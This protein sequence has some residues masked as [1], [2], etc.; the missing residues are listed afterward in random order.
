MKTILITIVMVLPCF[1]FGQSKVDD[2][3]I[4]SS[5]LKTYQYNN[6]VKF[7]YVIMVSSDYGKRNNES[8]IGGILE[9][10]RDYLKDGKDAG[11]FIQCWYFRDTLKKDTLWLPLIARLNKRIQKEHIIQNS[12]SKDLQV[13][14]LPYNEYIKY[15]DKDNG[16]D[17]DEGWTSF[18]ENY[19]GYSLLI[20]LSEIESDGKRAVFYLSH[21]C[22][23][24][25]GAGYMVL[26]Y[27]DASGWKFI[28]TLPI[29]M[30]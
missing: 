12:F 23:G 3:D 29:W 8:D 7:N 30:S 13:F 22:G 19:P 11:V 20:N 9:D 4:Y 17:I 6:N 28:G 26:F 21:Q 16:K 1:V 25:C 18:H 2:Y 5:Y 24:L 14:M 10:F 27:K 15:F